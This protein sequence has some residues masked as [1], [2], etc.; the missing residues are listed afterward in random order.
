MK[1]VIHLYYNRHNK[2]WYHKEDSLSDVKDYESNLLS[3][4]HEITKMIEYIN[5]Y[6][7]TDIDNLLNGLPISIRL[8]NNVRYLYIDFSDPVIQLH[9][10]E[11]KA[12]KLKMSLTQILANSVSNANNESSLVK[13]MD[14]LFI[15]KL[16]KDGTVKKTAII[17]NYLFSFIELISGIAYSDDIGTVDDYLSLADMNKI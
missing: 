9:K 7:Y 3:A 15:I 4:I 1:E 13:S 8:L 17:Y 11:I 14:K 16:E 6:S 2:T 10:Y 5:D 12:N